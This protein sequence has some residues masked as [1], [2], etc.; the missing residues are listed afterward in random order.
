MME[1]RGSTRRLVSQLPVNDP[2]PPAGYS[3]V[4]SDTSIPAFIRES[5]GP[6]KEQDSAPKVDQ[7]GVETIAEA[8]P[9]VISIYDRTKYTPDVRNHEMTHE[10]QS[11]RANGDIKLPFGYS[12]ATGTPNIAPMQ[13]QKGSLQNYD[14]GGETG[15]QSLRS[16]GKSAADL[17]VEQQADMVAD[18]KKK[19]DEYLALARSGK[20][21]PSVLRSMYNTYQAYHPFVQQMANLPKSNDFS[22]TIK[23]LLGLATG[24]LA[25]PP[26]PP[27][28]PAYDTPGLRVAP[29]D[30]LMGGSSVPV[31]K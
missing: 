2:K 20:A 29:A 27:G 1:R 31:R 3:V 6:I 22:T 8:N 14:Y 19:Q 21:T 9:G 16:S 12:L 25:P 24:P 13:Y 28:L 23:H 17:N 10:F 15:L 4:S 26:P 7:P 18:Y 30:P 5:L 11:T